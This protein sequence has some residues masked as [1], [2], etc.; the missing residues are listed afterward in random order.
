MYI[1]HVW[2]K[3][4]NVRNKRTRIAPKHEETPVVSNRGNYE[5]SMCKLTNNLFLYYLFLMKIV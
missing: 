5:K 1:A 4:K 2:V 3:K